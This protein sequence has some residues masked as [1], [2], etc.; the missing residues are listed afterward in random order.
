MKK[1]LVMSGI[2]II[3]L[4][5]AVVNAQQYFAPSPLS[6]YSGNINNY[7]PSYGKEECTA[8]QDFIVQIM[9]GGCSPAVV[10]SDLLEEQ[11][12]PVFC[13][14]TGIKINPLIQV[15]K[16]TSISIGRNNM[17]KDIAGIGFHP[18]RAA[19]RTNGNELTGSPIINNWGY[20][21]V[22]LKKQPI[23]KNMSKTVEASLNAVIQYQAEET[24][25]IGKAS[26][27]SPQISDELWQQNYKQYGFWKGKGYV[28]VSEIGSDSQGE[29]ARVDIYLDANRK[30]TSLLIREGQTYP[31]DVYLPGYYCQAALKVAVEGISSEP[32]PKAK[33]SVNNEVMWVSQGQKIAEDKCTVNTVEQDIYGSGQ[34]E[35]RCP[36]KLHKL[37]LNPAKATLSFEINGKET[38][39][40]VGV[41]EIIDSGTGAFVA[42]IGDTGKAANDK[43]RGIN[44]QF[45]VIGKPNNI[46][47]TDTHY[48]LISFKTRKII[49]GDK[50]NGFGKLTSQ[51]ALSFLANLKNLFNVGDKVPNIAEN[52]D[53]D[54]AK[55]LTETEFK[56]QL[57]AKLKKQFGDKIEFEVSMQEEKKDSL[58]G[59]KIIEN[60]IFK[61][62]ESSYDREYSQ[63]IG[64]V[65]EENYK[66]AIEEY[67]NIQTSYGEE[68]ST[69][70][71]GWKDE[72]IGAQALYSAAQL[73][74]YLEKFKTEAEILTELVEKYPDSKISEDALIHLQT[75][76][77]NDMTNAVS[78]AFISGKS[79]SMALEEVKDVSLN[80]KG[81][82][83]L[84][85]GNQGKYTVGDIIWEDVVI[86][87]IKD[88]YITIE[89]KT[90]TISKPALKKKDV[91]NIPYKAK[92]ADAKGDIIETPETITVQVV[93][94]MLVKE[95]RIKL[96]PLVERTETQTNFTFKIGIEKR[97]LKLSDAKAKEIITELDATIAQWKKLNNDLGNLIKAWKGTCFI[98]STYLIG[99]SF[100]SSF[101]GGS[102]ARNKVMRGGGG[103]WEKCTQLVN[104]DPKY[105]KDVHKC[106]A[107]NNDEIEQEVSVMKNSLGNVDAKV[108]ATTKM[109][110]GSNLL[111]NMKDTKASTAAYGADIK[112][113]Y[114]R[115][116]MDLS[117]TF[118]KE[119][120]DYVINNID[121]SGAYSSDLKEID[122]W[123]GV[124]NDPKSTTDQKEQAKKKLLSIMEPMKSD[125]D[126]AL[127]I[128]KSNEID[129]QN[130]VSDEY[131]KFDQVPI[132]EL[133]DTLK[134]ANIIETET[135]TLVIK[136]LN[137]EEKRRNTP[138]NKEIIQYTRQS[139]SLGKLYI[140]GT[141]SGGQLASNEIYHYVSADKTTVYLTELSA[142][143]KKQIPGGIIVKQLT[144]KD[145]S[146]NNVYKNPEVK[147]HEKAPDTGFPALVPLDKEKGWYVATKPAGMGI[148]SYESSGKIVSF[149]ICNVGANGLA[150]FF[151]NE[152]DDRYC[153]Q[154]NLDIETIDNKNLGTIGCLTEKETAI[155]VNHAQE[156]LRIAAERYA[157]GITSMN[158]DGFGNIPISAPPTITPSIE[159]EDFMS[160]KNCNLMFNVCDPVLCPSSRCN[161]GGKYTVPDVV[162]TGVVGGMLLCLP[163]F[164]KP[165]E[166]GVAVPVCL[167][168][169]HAGL[170]NYIMILNATKQCLQEQ[171]KSGRTVGIC[172]QIQSVYLCEFFW[173]QAMPLM[174]IGVPQ[175]VQ[176]V[177]GRG[178]VG[179]GGEYMDAQGA[180]T[181]LEKST[182]Y[183]TNYYGVNA[184]KAF[185]MRSTEEVGTEVCRSF[186]STR[187]PTSADGFNKLLEPESPTQFTA[188]FSEIVIT[189]ATV[190]ATSQYKVYI[191]VYA[192][193][194]QGI[195]YDVYLKGAPTTAYYQSLGQMQVPGAVGYIPTGEKV[196]QTIDFTGPAGYKELCVRINNQDKCGFTQVTTDFGVEEIKNLYL[197][198]QATNIIETEEE[199]IS[200]TPTVTP[201]M[202]LNIQQGVEE[203]LN[204][205]IYKQ[206]IIRICSS[207]NPAKTTHPSRYVEVGYCTD[208][209]IK[210]WLDGKSVNQSISDL[211]LANETLD[212]AKELI[213]QIDAEGYLTQDQAKDKF[214]EIDNLK[215]EDKSNVG[216]MKKIALE[217]GTIRNQYK[218]S[219]LDT[220][221]SR[222]ISAKID[223]IIT[224][225]ISRYRNIIEK[226]ITNDNKIKAN[227]EIAKIYNAITKYLYDDP[228]N[229][230]KSQAQTPVE[231]KPI[232]SKNILD[233]TKIVFGQRISVSESGLSE[234]VI[235]TDISGLSK[236]TFLAK[237][238]TSNTLWRY[239]YD[240]VTKTGSWNQET[241]T[242]ANK[243]EIEQ[244]TARS[245]DIN[246]DKMNRVTVTF[247]KDE[248]KTLLFNKNGYDVSVDF[249]GWGAANAQNK[250]V[251][252]FNSKTLS[253][254]STKLVEYDLD[255]DNKKD[256]GVDDTGRS[257]KSGS[258][259]SLIFTRLSK[260]SSKCSECNGFFAF[261]SM[262]QC[263]DKGECY[264]NYNPSFWKSSN[265]DYE[266]LS[267]WEDKVVNCNLFNN[268]DE[269]ENNKCGISGCLWAN[270]K[271]Q[272]ESEKQEQIISTAK[273]CAK[274]GAGLFNVCN[275]AEKCRGL[276]SCYTKIVGGFLGSYNCLNCDTNTKCSSLEREDECTWNKCNLDCLWA[277]NKGCLS[278][279]QIDIEVEAEDKWGYI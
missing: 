258:Y 215:G 71:E 117:D 167:S 109:V 86:K 23:E 190:P 230:F 157:N 100:F 268:L 105:N 206:G 244:T 175:L 87:D 31:Q 191:W 223:E 168:G 34:V 123:T 264:V 24:F 58:F 238:V 214:T 231:N 269:C 195:Y 92:K 178:G 188:K 246:L 13:Q 183:F 228:E 135:K 233:L 204:P 265:T 209:S 14:L 158:I 266:C 91:I 147:F 185:Q 274:C 232:S 90:L 218:I 66:N 33:I 184:F 70:E 160:A 227:F 57:A 82:T 241:V 5:C 9:P 254:T 150:E 140:I 260:I 247:N 213:K 108:K 94:I 189:D 143:E 207:E 10:R 202:Q 67:R 106:L 250:A 243:Q 176:S 27:I 62:L 54:A 171:I 77:Q 174:K 249:S 42:F 159:C 251:I 48:D 182:N 107:E 169:I 93:D 226:S 137:G 163:N 64:S 43:I 279:E 38:E 138:E 154:F 166:G 122:L 80:D 205:Q 208:K 179:G 261:C 125:V 142:D 40:T 98:T 181:N 173:K 96:T 210:C 276:G 277:D 149:W 199:C 30:L 271:C 177:F 63:D 170:E 112:T 49:E 128:E 19:L 35:I 145:L 144:A 124:Y 151:N 8:R 36:D 74:R 17:S 256:I 212:T 164:G 257:F 255:G 22:I 131:A 103:W 236:G 273:D 113:R 198:E 45:I 119:Q 41:K 252:L 132:L 12:V 186:I 180:W 263:H 7:W 11:N 270:G 216:L 141:L 242:A 192:G 155:L 114:A 20:L 78:T 267:C 3:L 197:K 101:G 139:T 99:Q 6:Y 61:G 79:Y 156:A 193:K 37:L 153:R 217:V 129:K 134:T 229:K 75:L 161:Y 28:R 146:C 88:E 72:P 44:K 110:Q 65:M 127:Q 104:E 18:A 203:S 130:G 97:A 148:Q 194:D 15:P 200:G 272:L 225:I 111:A 224:P 136:K 25:G 245:Y 235:V 95:A 2:V 133:K 196:D 240:G 52:D 259:I 47:M 222:E 76:K 221:P 46:I 21:V 172:D 118:K 201:M 219:K 39:K 59:N 83:L 115:Q 50:F 89:S 121:K 211:G 84:V 56:A 187:Y 68:K 162:Q 239:T 26:F 85:N 73:A 275:S 126:G 120:F 51:N 69:Y 234:E 116:G 55:A 237:G 262:A 81:V 60:F 253:I 220:M 16:I 1:M 53:F 152:K 32:K 102:S 4:A 29:F 165:S 278:D 248:K